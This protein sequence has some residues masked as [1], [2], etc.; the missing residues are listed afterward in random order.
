MKGSEQ[1]KTNEDE[2]DG[3]GDERGTAG[4]FS[5]GLDLSEN[6]LER[7][8][9][10][11]AHVRLEDVKRSPGKELDSAAHNTA[12]TTRSFL[13]KL[14]ILPLLA[15]M[16][17]SQRLWSHASTW[18]SHHPSGTLGASEHAAFPP[19]QAVHGETS[20]R[21]S[22]TESMVSQMVPS[23]DSR[24]TVAPRGLNRAAYEKTFSYPPAT[25]LPCLEEE[26]GA[27]WLPVDTSIS[28]KIPSGENDAA[29]AGAADIGAALPEEVPPGRGNAPAEADAASSGAPWC[30]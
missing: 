25:P 30:S 1:R 28:S 14:T 7:Y 8:R 20:E 5:P 18:T 23:G 16:L 3:G 11:T 19:E 29:M 13:L 21:E 27:D 26:S 10:A 4:L 24:S 15:C 22:R 6:E 17:G 9:A 12:P 2:G